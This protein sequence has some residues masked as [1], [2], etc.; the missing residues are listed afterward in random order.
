MRR[1]LAISFLTLAMASPSYADLV[2]TAS[3]NPLSGCGSPD[4][5][6]GTT[7]ANA[8]ACVSPQGGTASASIAFGITSSTIATY[9]F[10]D[11]AA[12]STDSSSSSLFDDE[13]VVTGGTGAGFLTLDFVES[14][15]GGGNDPQA[16]ANFEVLASLNGTQ[17]SDVRICGNPPATSGIVCTVPSDA[18]G[19][20]FTYGV[21]F[22]L[23]VALDAVAGGGLGGANI[24]G[25]GTLDYSLPS[26][27]V[28]TTFPASTVPE[29]AP[30]FLTMAGMSVLLIRRVTQ[31]KVSWS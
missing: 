10:D 3:V 11:V 6:V 31:G 14:G 28:L 5:V 22:E 8:S 20:A 29:P 17:Y 16:S 1:F 13:L 15:V 30:A 4:V 18:I 25:G 7:S 24:N 19:V 9:T 12:P 2:S 26:D 21:P 27:D 23:S